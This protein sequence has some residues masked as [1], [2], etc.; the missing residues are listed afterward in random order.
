MNHLLSILLIGTGA[1]MV[2]DLWSLVRKPLL[3][4]PPPNYGMVGRWI[5]YMAY[6]QFQHDAIA[7]SAPMRGERVTGWMFHYLTGIAYAALLI[8][9]WGNSWI[10]T[11]TLGPALAVGIITVAAPFLLMQPGM[12]AGI[13]ASRTPK[14]NSARLQS[15]ITHAVF[16]LGLYVSGWAIQFFSQL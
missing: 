7:A 2:M 14:P 9:I 11:P 6:G 13:A 15:L 16:G 12:G 8:A 4:I 10:H 3:G 1:T 5:T